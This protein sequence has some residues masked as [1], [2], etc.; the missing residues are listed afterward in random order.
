MKICIVSVGVGGLP[1]PAVKGGAV[2]NLIDNYLS[3]NEKYNHDE[4]TVVSC[5]HKEAREASK[6][7][8][9]A[10]FVYIDIH[11][12]KYKI[13][14]TIRY[15]INK[16]SP[17]FVGNAYI[18]QLPDLSGFDTVLIENRPEYGYY[19]RKKF[20]GNLVLH[21]HNDLLMDNE[22]SVDY[23]VYDKLITI[24]DYIRDRSEV[25]MS[26][27]PIQTVYNGIDTELFLQ[28]FSEIDLSDLKN[29]LEILSDDFVII[30]FGRINKNKGIKELLEAFLLLPKNLNIKLLA[31]GS[32]IFGQTE[33]DTFTTELRQLAKQ[34][35][36]KVVFT[37]YVNYKDI[38]KYHHIA[39]C[40]VVPSIWE[41]PA[42]LTVCEALISGKYVITTDAGGIPEIVA[43]SEALVVANDECIVEHLKTAL[44]SVY[45]K[46][47]C[48]SVI[49][50]NRDRGAYFSIEKYGRD[51]RKELTQNE[52]I[53][54]I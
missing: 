48:S 7:Y 8:K 37:G 40:I 16:Y 21:L 22:Y 30:F 25:V 32:S 26:G 2:E 19:I 44:L 41:E 49:T 17:F 43:G 11:S 3:Y 14:K 20:K 31:V 46:G 23:S 39:D 35:S 6:K 34:A 10:Q 24:S 4:I 1:I 42:G 12:L 9:Y 54:N 53:I 36:D 52:R 33:L 18:S 51:L 50:S 45:Q 13:N 47:K 5:D 38:P 27:V 15:A 28:N 29:Q